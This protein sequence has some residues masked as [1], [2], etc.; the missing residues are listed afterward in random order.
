MNLTLSDLNSSIIRICQSLCQD[1]IGIEGMFGHSIWE[2][3]I[4]SEWKKLLE[5]EPDKNRK[6]EM[7]W[8]SHGSSVTCAS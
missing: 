4:T 6:Y 1:Y 5:V 3:E 7:N 8:N 2:M